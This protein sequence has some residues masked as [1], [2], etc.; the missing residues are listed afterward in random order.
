MADWDEDTKTT[1]NVNDDDV[2][3]NL[4]RDL[5]YDR[6]GEMTVGEWNGIWARAGAGIMH[7][8]IGHTALVTRELADKALRHC[9]EGEFPHCIVEDETRLIWPIQKA[10]LS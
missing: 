7:T 10:C 2:A 1:I 8:S 9:M 6:R 3:V 5:F 4:V